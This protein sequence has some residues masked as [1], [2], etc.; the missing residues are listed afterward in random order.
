MP[1]DLLIALVGGLFAVVFFTL[2][3]RTGWRS[4]WQFDAHSSFGSWFIGLS[5][6]AAL[7][8]LLIALVSMREG[9]STGDVLSALMSV[10]LLGYIVI[11]ARGGWPRG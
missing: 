5:L 4:S 1:G 2:L 9:A 3:R 8:T 10:L 11:L 7:V 6:A